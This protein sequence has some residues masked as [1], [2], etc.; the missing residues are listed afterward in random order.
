[1]AA[2]VKGVTASEGPGGGEMLDLGFEV[3][4]GIEGTY[5]RP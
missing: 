3:R 2:L 4:E 5:S 1:M